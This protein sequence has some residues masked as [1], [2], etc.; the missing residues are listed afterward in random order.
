MFSSGLRKNKKMSDLE[1]VF[2]ELQDVL[3][4]SQQA[5]DKYEHL[6]QLQP[7]DEDYDLIFAFYKDDDDP[8]KLT[9]DEL[10]KTVCLI[11]LGTMFWC[12]LT[13]CRVACHRLPIG[14]RTSTNWETVRL[15]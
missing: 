9:R 15:N 6:Q 3:A 10:Q 4:L 14:V 7:G 5:I 11:L 13:E 8:T 12:T 2:A 1:E